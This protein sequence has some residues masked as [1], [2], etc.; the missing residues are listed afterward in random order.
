MSGE[1]E[2]LTLLESERDCLIRAARKVQQELEQEIQRLVDLGRGGIS[3]TTTTR[4]FVASEF[5]CIT[6]A[7]RKLWQLRKA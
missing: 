3:G 4:E 5:S 2:P 7:T 1:M 6:A